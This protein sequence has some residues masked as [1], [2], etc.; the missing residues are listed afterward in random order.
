MPPT[1]DLIPKVDYEPV[2]IVPTGGWCDDCLLP[3]VMRCT[4]AQTVSVAHRSVTAIGS[5]LF[6]SDCGKTMGR[7]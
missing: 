5:V 7:G 2:A 3:S 1:P 6:C 4:F